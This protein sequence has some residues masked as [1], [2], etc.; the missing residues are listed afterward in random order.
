[1]Q[2]SRE[3][4]PFLTEVMKKHGSIDLPAE[5]NSMFPFIQAGD[6]CRFVS[7][8]PLTLKKGDIVLFQTAAGHFVAHRLHRILSAGDQPRYICKG[9]TNLGTDEPVG[10]DRILGKLDAI[11]TNKAIRKYEL[12]AH[13]WSKMILTFPLLTPL[14]RTY[15]NKREHIQS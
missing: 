2:A 1:M 3:T 4:L 7:C 12:V 13:V 14:L 6:I 8:D 9:D 11:Q 10:Q 15:L 5:G